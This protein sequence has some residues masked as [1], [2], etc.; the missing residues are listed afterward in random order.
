MK[1]QDLTEGSLLG[2]LC[3][4]A[5]PFLLANLLQSLYGAVDLF[6]V[7]KYCDAK[8]VAAVSTGTQV[9]QIVTSL[10]SGLTLGSTI[11]IGNYI[12]QKNLEM[13]KRAIGTTLTVFSVFALLLTGLMLIF[14]APLLTV[15]NTPEESFELTMSYVAV[16]AW[17][18]FLSVDIIL[19]VLFYV[20]VEIP[21]DL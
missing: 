19:S 4:F 5:V 16:C 12:G 3:M 6:V 17:G 15:L 21:K 13:V 1:Q 7:G 20:D 8:S 11:V 18:N 14:E 10:S 2:T 9:T